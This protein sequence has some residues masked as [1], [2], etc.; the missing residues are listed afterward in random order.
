[1]SKHRHTVHHHK[2]H[3][4]KKGFG[5]LFKKHKKGSNRGLGLFR[6]VSERERM[7][8]HATMTLAYIRNGVV[9]AFY[10]A[11]VVACVKLTPILLFGFKLMFRS[12]LPLTGLALFGTNRGLFPNLKDDH[13]NDDDVQIDDDEDDDDDELD[14]EDRDISEEDEEKEKTN[15]Y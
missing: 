14:D 4:H 1:M 10:T 11:L 12:V 15:K 3:S 5:K 2:K 13:H 6:R 8:R 9:N 7:E